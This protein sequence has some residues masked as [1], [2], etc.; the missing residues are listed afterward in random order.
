MTNWLKDLFQVIIFNFKY[1][2]RNMSRVFFI[3]LI[4]LMLLIIPVFFVPLYLCVG[5]IITTTIVLTTGISFNSLSSNFKNSNFSKNYK[6]IRE[7]YIMYNTSIVVVSIAL[8]TIALV[9]LLFFVY[10]FSITNL[11]QTQLLFDNNKEEIY[12][13]Y[14][15]YFDWSGFIYTIGL[16]FAITIA[17][18]ATVD[19]MTKSNVVAYIVLMIIVICIVIFGSLF[20]NYYQGYYVNDD[21][22]ISPYLHKFGFPEAML[23]PSSIIFPWYNTSQLINLSVSGSIRHSLDPE[24][25]S[26]FEYMSDVLLIDSKPSLFDCFTTPSLW[27]FDSLESIGWDFILIMPYIHF[28]SLFTISYAVN[29]YKY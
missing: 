17:F 1:F 26:R 21:G 3:V 19:A 12:S 6:L 23:I 29:K 14:L 10:I 27:K 20:N 4:P 2:I 5:L 15:R 24:F 16:T 18:V 7:D 13:Y 9:G 11:L 8:S 22:D 28:F 25:T